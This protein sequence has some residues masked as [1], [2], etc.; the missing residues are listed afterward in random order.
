MA[1]KMKGHGQL[2]KGPA[3][4]PPRRPRTI[5]DR[6]PLKIPRTRHPETFG[7]RRHAKA[8]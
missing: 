1:G 4:T 3:Q 7:V 8:V 2:H 6:K 5:V